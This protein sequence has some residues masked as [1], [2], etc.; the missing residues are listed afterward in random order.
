MARRSRPTPGGF[1][2]RTRR[3]AIASTP[4]STTA[5][6]TKPPSTQSPPTSRPRVSARSGQRIGCA[7]GASRGSATGARRFRSSTA[8]RAATCRCPRRTCP[9]C[10]PR[11]ACPTAAAIRSRSARISSIHRARRCGTPAK[12]E[13]DTMDTFVDS[14]WY[15]MRYACPDAPTMVDR[16]QRLLEPDGPVH[17]RHRARDP[18]PPLCALLDQ[19]DAR[20][21]PRQVR[22]AL[23]ATADAGDGAQPHLFPPHRE[24]RH[25]LLR[26]RG[27]SRSRTT[28]KGASSGRRPEPTA[29]RVEYGG[30]GHDVEE[31]SA[32]ASIRR[33]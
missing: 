9:S 11:I 30:I 1:G 13:T 17:R 3:V 10:C 23:H 7:T 20:H 29:Q 22:R 18:A 8:R 24:G 21:G 25:R 4:A 32:T 26:A 28:P 6:L 2:T 31:R 16:P 15:Y 14:S 27:P 19:G 12:R 33:S 5:S